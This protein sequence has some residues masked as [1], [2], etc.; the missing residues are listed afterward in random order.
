L[1]ERYKDNPSIH[2]DLDP[3]L[4]LEIRLSGGPDK[5]QVY[6]LSNT[7][8]QNLRMARSVSIVECLQSV[9]STQTLE[10]TAML[11]HW[12][13]DQTTH[14]NKKYKYLTTDYEEFWKMVMKMRSHMGHPC[15]PYWPHGLGDN[16]P[17][18]PPSSLLF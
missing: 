11:Y 12:V 15:A 16:Q 5:N 14:L 9:L 3:N 13:H 18:P 10:F 4:W 6:G 17:P 7:T 1:K 8:T 2:L